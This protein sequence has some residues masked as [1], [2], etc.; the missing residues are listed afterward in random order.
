M[1]NYSYVQF[2][3]EFAT[4]GLKSEVKC[5]VILGYINVGI[6]ALLLL[7]MGYLVAVIDILI[8]VGATVTLQKTKKWGAALVFIIYCG[9]SILSYLGA[10]GE[11]RGGAAIVFIVA[12]MT[13]GGLKKI[14]EAY[15]EYQLSGTIPAEQIDKWNP[16]A[17]KDKK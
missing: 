14:G 8:L 13:A 10:T 7:L 6:S 5:L 17:R 11:I 16:L 1:S 4:K 3:E 9:I 15:K 12:L 2:Y